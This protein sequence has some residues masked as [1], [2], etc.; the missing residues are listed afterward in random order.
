MVARVSR[1][2]AI[3]A[4]H[5]QVALGDSHVEDAL[6]AGHLAVGDVGLVDLNPVDAHL[7]GRALAGHVVAAH[8]D[9]ALDER[10]FCTAGH[11]AGELAD[12]ARDR[13]GGNIGA[14]KPSERVVED[15]DVAAV[16]VGAQRVDTRDSDTVIL[17]QGVAHRR[18]GDPEDLHDKGAQ[19]RGD[20]KRDDDNDDDLAQPHPGV[21]PGSRLSALAI[22]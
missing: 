13:R 20:Q 10:L 11:E 1:V 9:D 7:A 17:H 14:S 8:A 12:L 3:I 15:D 5:P 6:A 22:P 21:A 19:Q 2:R 18:R 16:N 4:H